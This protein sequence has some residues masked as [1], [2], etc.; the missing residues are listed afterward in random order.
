MALSCF[1]PLAL[2]PIGPLLCYP[3]DTPALSHWLSPH[4]KSHW[5]SPVLSRWF[6]PVLS[7]WLSPALPQL[8]AA[9]LS[10]IGSLFMFFPIGSFLINLLAL[11]SYIF[12]FA[13]SS[14]SFPVALYLL[15]N[16]LSLSCTFPLVL[17]CSVLP[18][19]RRGLFNPSGFFVILYVV[20][21]LFCRLSPSS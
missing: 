13:L 19:W 11:S 4:V 7:N 1:I 8:L 14:C 18:F 17:S 6:S 9:A 12:Q 21:F 3:T 5:L 16:P 15:F 20:C 10:N 2:Y